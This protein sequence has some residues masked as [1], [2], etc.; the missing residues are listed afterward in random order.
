MFKLIIK[1]IYIVVMAIFVVMVG[2]ILAEKYGPS[3][4]AKISNVTSSAD[5]E[6]QGVQRT[7]K[8]WNKNILD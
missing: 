5:R 8:D 4:S 3:I 1:H 2:N 6:V 7:V